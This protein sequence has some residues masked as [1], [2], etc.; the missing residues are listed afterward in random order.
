MSTGS[1]R[2]S[3]PSDE[4]PELIGDIYNRSILPVS[5]S[6]LLE[7]IATVEGWRAALLQFRQIDEN[8]ARDRFMALTACLQRGRI[9]NGC[10]NLPLG[11]PKLEDAV[12]DL[13]QIRAAPVLRTGR[14]KRRSMKC[15]KR[16]CQPRPLH[17]RRPRARRPTRRPAS[18]AARVINQPYPSKACEP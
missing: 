3:I 18:P 6:R 17:A 9:Y 4:E 16:S 13:W 5:P 15:C 2:A 1:G 8:S 11:L 14:R 10:G 7:I 12:W